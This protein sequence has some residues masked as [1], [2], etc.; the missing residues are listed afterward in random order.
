MVWGVIP[1]LCAENA[2]FDDM[3][4]AGRRAALERNLGRAGERFVLTAG[5]PMNVPG[6][7]NFLLVETL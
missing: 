2:T 4:A 7:T 5:R 3:L 6:T 1:V